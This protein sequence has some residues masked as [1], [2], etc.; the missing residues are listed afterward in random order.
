M[1]IYIRKSNALVNCFWARTY[2]LAMIAVQQWLAHNCDYEFALTLEF[3]K[4]NCIVH[5]FI[6]VENSEPYQLY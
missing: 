2:R 1:T 4:D 3:V 5:K 6:L